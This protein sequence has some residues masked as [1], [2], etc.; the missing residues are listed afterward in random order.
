MTDVANRAAAVVVHYGHAAPTRRAVLAIA[1]DAP[2]IPIVVVDNGADPGAAFPG[3]RRVDAGGNRGYG[4][5]CNLGAAGLAAEYLLFFNNDV[6]VEPGCLAALVAALDAN[7]RAAVAAPRLSDAEGRAVASIFRAPTPRR[8][9]FENLFLPRLLP[10]SLFDGHHTTHI[11]H[12]EPRV[13]ETVSGAVFAVRT[14][15]FAQVGG[16]DEGYFFYAEE[17]DLFARL[18]NAGWSI[19][20]APAARARHLGGLA[21]ASIPQARRD[22]WLHGG[23]RRYARKFHGE[24]GE[25][26]VVRSL[27]LGAHLRFWLAFLQPGEIGRSRRRRYADILHARFTQEE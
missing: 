13:V 18:R 3:A 8:V 5:A 2:G 22:K 14:E 9:L 15:A 20:F 24:R 7:P 6:E 23:L 12:E 26:S 16:F 11:P 1:R 19:R 10:F 17:S 21:S 25:R 27:R 4:A